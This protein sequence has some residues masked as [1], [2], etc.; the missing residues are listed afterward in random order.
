VSFLQAYYTSS[1]L[2]LS[3]GQGFQFHAVTSGIDSPTLGQMERLGVY[4]PPRSAPVHPTPEELEH[5]P[6]ALAYTILQDGRAVVLQSRYVGLDYSGRWGNYFAHFLISSAPGNDFQDFLPI[7]LWRSP[8]WN[9]RE[10][11]ETS[12]QPLAEADLLGELDVESVARFVSEEGRREHLAD[13]L[14]AIET[15]LTTSRRVIIV[16]RDD[17][18]A[19]WIAAAA[20]ALPKSLALAL[21]FSTY[22]KAPQDSAAL[23]VGTTPDSDFRIGPF[24][25]A[26][27]YFVFDFAGNRFSEIET[28]SRFAREC[29]RAYEQR[30]GD[31]VGGFGRFV[32][33]VESRPNV[34]M[35]SSAWLAYALGAGADVDTPASAEDIAWLRRALPVYTEEQVVAL[36]D[37]LVSSDP[38]LPMIDSILDLYRDARSH[39]AVSPI[40]SARVLPW[41]VDAAL[42]PRALALLRRVIDLGPLDPDAAEPVRHLVPQ[43]VAA[44]ERAPGAAET[45]LLLEAGRR[46][47]FEPSEED[48][49]RLGR[50]VARFVA[51]EAVERGI[52][53]FPASYEGIWNHYH[54]QID[55]GGDLSA[56]S[57][58][59][60]REEIQSSATDFAVARQDLRFYIHLIAAMDPDNHL[61]VFE[62]CMDAARSFVGRIEAAHVDLLAAIIW[63]QESP[64]ASDATAILHCCG[65]VITGTRLLGRLTE[66]LFVGT[67]PAHAVDELL[68]T[69]QRPDILGA[70]GERAA[71]VEAAAV[72]QQLRQG[73]RERTAPALDHA[74]ML[75][76]RGR[77]S[78]IAEHSLAGTAAAAILTIH[79][80]RDHAA[81][82][83]RASKHSDEFRR[84]YAARVEQRLTRP[85]DISIA[86]AATL[87]R[88]WL[89]GADGGDSTCGSLIHDLLPRAARGWSKHELA[90]VG[91]KLSVDDPAAADAWRTWCE[92]IDRGG[93]LDSLRRIWNTR[94]GPTDG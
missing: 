75:L 64:S 3:G 63:R 78:P 81:L 86:T 48:G 47:R 38:D 42:R 87:F 58:W 21:T 11:S 53:S 73:Q 52:A 12:L 91:R 8:S 49:H 40:A 6:V 70:L 39:P 41:L 72:L 45:S 5:L 33:R 35:L 19:N 14:S 77:M 26:H 60:R 23:V 37:A 36:F 4:V 90:T 65:A 24:E 54:E 94:R 67:A 1:T 25:I 71:D 44:I 32:E 85:T 62:H 80:P 92:G 13:F 31:Y 56:L 50:A 59:L 83:C 10:R 51:D 57:V 20:F 15:S 79:D 34:A 46:L 28:H 22:V 18:V 93:V 82:L 88:A 2:G 68:Q 61:H 69:L 43:W 17:H 30:H 76:G 84:E 16:D 66:P 89:T 7:E 29:A 27:Q 55:R 74:T 9:T